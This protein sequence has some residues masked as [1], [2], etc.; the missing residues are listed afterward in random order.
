VG[1]RV[2]K[3]AGNA[4]ALVCDPASVRLLALARVTLGPLPCRGGQRSAR[5]DRVSDGE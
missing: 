4:K 2:V 3:L 1:E 5:A